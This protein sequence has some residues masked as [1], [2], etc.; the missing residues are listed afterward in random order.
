MKER[1]RAI[2]AGGGFGGLTAATALAQRGWSVT[3]Y[4][5]QPEL[6]ASGS[7]IYI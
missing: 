2:V 4:E 3:I 7:G 1:L 6:R 5:R